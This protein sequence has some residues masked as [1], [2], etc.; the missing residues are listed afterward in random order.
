MAWDYRHLSDH[1]GELLLV[2][3]EGFAG[4]H[5]NMVRL[6]QAWFQSQ[7]SPLFPTGAAGHP[8][9]GM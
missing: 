4:F 2:F 1:Y 5:G 3:V 8:E 7:D 9:P 6:M